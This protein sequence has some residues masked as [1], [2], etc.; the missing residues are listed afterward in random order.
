MSEG[1]LGINNFY[2]GYIEGWIGG[3]KQT[4]THLMKKDNQKDTK[5]G[6]IVI[7]L[8]RYL[9]KNPSKRYRELY[10]LIGDLLS[11]E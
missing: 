3:K 1:E 7:L 10:L 4:L 2:N 9:D 5:S 6:S 8:K 11:K